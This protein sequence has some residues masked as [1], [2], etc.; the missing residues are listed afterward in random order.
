MKRPSKISL[1]MLL[2]VAICLVFERPVKASDFNFTVETTT[3]DNQINSDV[4]WFN[5]LVEPG[6]VQTLELYLRNHMDE[7]IVIAID[8]AAATTNLGGVVEYRTRDDIDRDATLVHDLADLI[9]FPD[10]VEIP[11]GESVT[12]E[13][14]LSIPAEDFEGMIA[15]GVTLSMQDLEADEDEAYGATRIRNRFAYEIAITLQISEDMPLPNFEVGEAWADYL[16]ARN[17]IFVNIQNTEATFVTWVSLTGRVYPR[18][19]TTWLWSEVTVPQS[20]MFAPNSNMDFPIHLNAVLMEAGDYTACVTVATS[21]L[22]EE[23][24]WEDLCTDFTITPEQAAALTMDNLN[25]LNPNY[26]WLLIAL[27]VVLVSLF[28]VLDIFILRVIREIRALREIKRSL[29]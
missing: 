16:N 27:I 6:E 28:V 1:I 9:T 22:E 25:N 11:V 13:L 21:G 24:V 26:I 29:K 18:G 17:V 4:T 10:E 12:L 7:D 20:M 14:E 15:G 3:P 23:M 19:G 5:L 8:I 2:V